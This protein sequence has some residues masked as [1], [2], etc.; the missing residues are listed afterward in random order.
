[1]YIQQVYL[2]NIIKMRYGI[3]H[4]VRRYVALPQHRGGTRFCRLTAVLRYSLRLQN[5]RVG[6]NRDTTV[7][8]PGGSR[9]GPYRRPLSC[10][11]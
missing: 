9:G 7:G 10:P 11:L 2:N 1:M 5:Y 4:N 3:Q 6:K 8:V